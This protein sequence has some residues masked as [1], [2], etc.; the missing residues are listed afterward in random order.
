M[1][2]ARGISTMGRVCSPSVHTRPPTDAIGTFPPSL[3][4]TSNN[5]PNTSIPS[6]THEKQ[7]PSPV[8]G[9]L[10]VLRS[11]HVNQG[12]L[13]ETILITSFL[14]TIHT[15]SIIQ[16]HPSHSSCVQA[17]AYADWYHPP[18]KLSINKSSASSLSSTLSNLPSKNTATY[19]A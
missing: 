16:A 8:K 14:P 5:M 4:R 15:L 2:I 17:C 11:K 9:G 10:S 12:R 1:R 18:K 13:M 6:T 19:L 3:L 7:T